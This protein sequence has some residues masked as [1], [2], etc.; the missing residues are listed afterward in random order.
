MFYMNKIQ[1]IKNYFKKLSVCENCSSIFIAELGLCESCYKN[2]NKL[3]GHSSE[4]LSTRRLI[5]NK[6]I[7]IRYMF[8]WRPDENRP[9]SQIIKSHKGNTQEN[10]WNETAQVFCQKLTAT[11]QVETNIVFIPVG[12][13]IRSKDHAFCFALQLSKICGSEIRFALVKKQLFSQKNESFLARSKIEFLAIEKFTQ[14]E[15]KKYKFIL[16]DDVVTTGHTAFAAY[17]ALSY[18]DNFEV[19]CL[20][21]RAL[22]D[23]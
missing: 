9:L 3:A 7:C 23:L 12:N 1:T 16:V 4:L 22:A 8:N 10:F 11:C 2:L 20:A 19:W 18:P 14:A 17:K 15:L 5:G 13:A 6:L 21:V